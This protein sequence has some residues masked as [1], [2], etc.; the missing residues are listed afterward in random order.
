MKKY[1][2]LGFFFCILSIL[3]LISLPLRIEAEEK[4]LITANEGE[5]SLYALDENYASVL[6]IPSKYPQSFQLEGFGNS[7][8]LRFYVAE[9]D[10]VEVSENGLITPAATIWY[11]NGNI[12]STVSSGAEDE[13]VSVEYNFG[14]SV[15]AV[16]TGEETL[17]FTVTVYNYAEIY[18]EAV[19]EQYVQQNITDSM[20]E[21]EKLEVI[22][23]FPAKYDYS[24][25][26]SGYVSM[27]VFGGGD[28]WASSST[29][30]R[31]CELTGLEAHLRY[32]ANEPGAGG[33]HRNVAV[34]IG[35]TVYIA[36]AGYDEMAPRYYSVRP[37]NTGFYYHVYDGKAK[38]IQYDGFE[39]NV[40]VPSEID[41]YPITGIESGAF[42]YAE[43]YS[44][45]TIESVTLPDTIETIGEAA[46]NSC[47][48]LK[49]IMIPASVTQIEGLAFTN[50]TSL[51]RIC[52]A[53]ENQNYKDING[54]LY[55]K[56]GTQLL[57]YPGGRTGVYTVP[58]GVEDIT[59]Y[60]FYY[61]KGV[62][63]VVFPE[64]LKHIGIG[65]F[66]DSNVNWMCFTGVMPEIEIY[67]FR[68]LDLT[69][70]YPKGDSTWNT[71]DGYG[72]LSVEWKGYTDI[73]PVLD[74]TKIILG[75]CNEDS[76]IT[77]E[78]ALA[79]LKE[80]VGISQPVFI[81]E[82]ADCNGDENITAEDAL[83]VLK[84][85]VG[86]ESLG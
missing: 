30:L 37:E 69:V 18:A 42:M 55:N 34:K 13:V 12:G 75:D 80:V 84:H 70:Y 32:G 5:I 61:T 36:E 43:T 45:I 81:L 38:I 9:G 20:T 21:L 29:I 25:Y 85:V 66:G 46:F 68:Y 77:A 59:E 71:E 16:W 44:G 79:I 83:A 73:A 54:V 8:Y 67:A 11:W 41:G 82:A 63:K 56:E 60:A 62:K 53:E 17:Y 76:K 78:D 72:A 40:S 19:L 33:G 28:C 74:E 4:T 26:Y 49:E 10:S 2:A 50:C 15:V 7:Q 27:I 52:V 6:T 3:I 51:E 86:I 48:H 35:D 24:A 22:T 47:V 58:E 39:E 31:L 23:A 64:S 57:F 1:P 14:D 65:A